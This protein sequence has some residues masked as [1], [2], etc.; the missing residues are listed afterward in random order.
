MIRKLLATAVTVAACT[1]N[2]PAAHAAVVRAGC[3]F[4]SVDTDTVLGDGDTYT[5]YAYGYAT[6]DD[7]GPHTLRCVVTVDY[8]RQEATGAGWGRL[9]VTTEGPVTYVAP[10]GSE[11]NL[12][13]EIDGGELSCPVATGPGFPPQAVVDLLGP[14]GPV[15]CLLLHC[16]A[17]RHP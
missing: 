5:G 12:C 6:F 10:E 15:A 17:R 3:G 7:P 1:L 8:V 11:A 2:V 14:A 9:A 13:V 4:D 16:S